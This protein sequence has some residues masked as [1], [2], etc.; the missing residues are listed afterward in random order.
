MATEIPEQKPII[1]S[2]QLRVNMLS[3]II[4]AVINTVAL[5]AVYP[6]D[7]PVSKVILFGSIAQR[8]AEKMH[9]HQQ[10]KN[11]VRL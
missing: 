6:I 7:L 11:L 3:G 2:S 10:S 8:P 9:G 4:T 1:M 5:A